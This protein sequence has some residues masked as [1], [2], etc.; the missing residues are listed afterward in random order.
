MM[1]RLLNRQN[2][3]LTVLPKRLPHPRFLSTEKNTETHEWTLSEPSSYDDSCN[4][5][6]WEFSIGINGRPSFRDLLFFGWSLYI[7]NELCAKIFGSGKKSITIYE[8]FKCFKYWIQIFAIDWRC[9]LYWNI[10]VFSKSR[11]NVCC[12]CWS[13]KF[14]L[15]LFIICLNW[16]N[17]S[18]CVCVCVWKTLYTYHILDDAN[19]ILCDIC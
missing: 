15:W 18:E 3:W 19:G 14:I 11:R 1:I 16:L 13:M 9:L 10:N 8:M 2:E 5:L 12:V 7:F 17:I 4:S 6:S